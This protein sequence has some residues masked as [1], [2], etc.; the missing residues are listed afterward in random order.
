MSISYTDKEVK[1]VTGREGHER[2]TRLCSATGTPFP[3]M[4]KGKRVDKVEKKYVQV[5]PAVWKAEKSPKK[6]PSLNNI[7]EVI[8]RKCEISESENRRGLERTR[9]C[10]IHTLKRTGNGL[11]VDTSRK[12]L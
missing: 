1:L 9:F 5:I 10:R 12:R 6:V 11:E 8:E 2:L 4:N 3:F 7:L